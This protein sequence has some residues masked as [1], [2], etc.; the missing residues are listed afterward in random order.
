MP[1]TNPEDSMIVGIPNPTHPIS[2]FEAIIEEIDNVINEKHPIPDSMNER[3][4]T[5][6]AHGLYGKKERRRLGRLRV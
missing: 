5:R 6:K 4:E 3:E 2:D 1:A